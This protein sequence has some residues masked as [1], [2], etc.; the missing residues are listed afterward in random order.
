MNDG[1]VSKL[2]VP[3]FPLGPALI[4]AV[5]CRLAGEMQCCIVLVKLAGEIQSGIRYRVFGR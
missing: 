4:T 1:L 3:S 5:A 2:F